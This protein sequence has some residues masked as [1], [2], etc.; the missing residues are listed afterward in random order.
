M[1]LLIHPPVE[2]ARLNKIV[3]A[4]GE[5]RVVNA[6]GEAEAMR[7][8]EDA[9]AFFGKLTEIAGTKLRRPEPECEVAAA[10]GPSSPAVR[11]AAPFTEIQPR[12]HYI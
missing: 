2:P 5:M 9:D 12:I 3:A 10:A 1:K 11:A 6:A 4:A 8:V 7:E